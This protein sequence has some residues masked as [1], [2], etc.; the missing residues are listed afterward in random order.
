MFLDYLYFHWKYR[1]SSNIH[2]SDPLSIQKFTIGQLITETIQACGL[3][4]TLVFEEALNIII[5]GI[6]V[7]Q[8]MGEIVEC[9]VPNVSGKQGLE[10]LQE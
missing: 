2:Q 4:S 1:Q 10:S 6:N 5:K 3:V 9:M 8:K 7:T